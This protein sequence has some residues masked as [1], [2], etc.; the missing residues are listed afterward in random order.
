M[1]YTTISDTIDDYDEYLDETSDVVTVAGYQFFPSSVLEKMDPCAYK[2]EW[3]QWC[4]A[5]G[6]NTDDLEDDYT[7]EWDK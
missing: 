3:L 1:T 4:D 2:T 6:I 5:L 7:F